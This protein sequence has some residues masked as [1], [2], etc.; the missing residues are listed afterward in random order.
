MHIFQP[1][2]EIERMYKKDSFREDLSKLP[3][4]IAKEISTDK[5]STI[6]LFIGSNPNKYGYGYLIGYGKLNIPIIINK[7]NEKI[8]AKYFYYRYDLEK[9]NMV[10]F[11]FNYPVTPL[12]FKYCSNEERKKSIYYQTI[13]ES[14]NYGSK[15]FWRNLSIKDLTEE[16]LEYLLFIEK[17][18]EISKQYNFIKILEQIKKN[19][20]ISE[21][22]ERE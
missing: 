10:D 17:V 14:Y 4:D 18:Q 12:F 13:L 11:H 6:S 16:D 19:H 3:D 7:N 22:Y 9:N 1:G 21:E 5:I 15:A 8:K 20:Y 2:F